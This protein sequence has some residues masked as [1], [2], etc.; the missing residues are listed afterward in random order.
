MIHFKFFICTLFMLS[1]LC[2][3]SVSSNESDNQASSNWQQDSVLK[4]VQSQLPKNWSM[5]IQKDELIVE[6][7]EPVWVLFENQIN[8][9]L[10]LESQEKR[11]ERI[12]KYGHETKARLTFRCESKWS[13]AKIEQTKK[14]NDLVYK[15]MDALIDKYNIRHLMDKNLNSKDGDLFIPKNSDDK[16]RIKDYY[17]AKNEV[18]KELKKLPDYNT[19]KYSLFLID[20][21]G[22]ND[23][24]HIVH[25]PEISAQIYQIQQL[26]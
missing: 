7:S 23:D 3:S 14:D 11:I 15:K 10:D 13:D 5:K 26:F 17:A 20:T 1:V 4:K 16:K 24:F 6:C 22:Y 8:A 9:P 12:K 2:C 19:E 21:I 18:E 25:P